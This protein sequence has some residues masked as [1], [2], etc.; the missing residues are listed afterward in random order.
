M[1][2]RGITVEIAEQIRLKKGLGAG[3]KLRQLRV[4][5]G[6]SQSKLAELSGIA[7][8]TLQKYEQKEINI[9]NA[10][11]TNLCALCEA[12]ECSIGDIIEDTE[13][14]KRYMNVR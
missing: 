7:S 13:L 6:Y 11:L 10:S 3:V 12:L 9:D 5:K 1:K 14:L 4:K 8:K 2:K